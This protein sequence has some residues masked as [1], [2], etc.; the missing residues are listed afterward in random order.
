MV[1]LG[2]LGV[3][4]VLVVV[5]VLA[6]EVGLLLEGGGEL[7]AGVLLVLGVELLV[8]AVLREGLLLHLELVVVVHLVVLLGLGGLGRGW[9]HVD[10]RKLWGNR[11]A[12]GVLRL[13]LGRRRR[14][15]VRGLLAPLQL[16]KG[17]HV[18]VWKS[19]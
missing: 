16:L 17:I 12:E 19:R 5:G 13:L 14:G 4:P 11:S 7:G 3:A 9:R 2:R 8:L 15:R 6:I 18:C 1:E 10:L